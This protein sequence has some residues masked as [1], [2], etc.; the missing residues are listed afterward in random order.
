MKEIKRILR[1][2]IIGEMFIYLDR[3]DIYLNIDIY[4]DIYLVKKG[5]F[6]EKV[7][8]IFER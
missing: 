7:D 3:K 5:L 2:K 6:K 8:L 4:L 1:E